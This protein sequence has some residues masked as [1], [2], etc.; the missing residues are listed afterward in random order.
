MVT[1]H[2]FKMPVFYG[3]STDTKPTGMNGMNGAKFIEIDTHAEFY[4]DEAGD[5]W[6]AKPEPETPDSTPDAD[7]DA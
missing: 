3:L 6:C 1:V 2:D 4:Y 5:Q 7:A